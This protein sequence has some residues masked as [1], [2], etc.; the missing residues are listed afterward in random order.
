MDKLFVNG[1]V[2]LKG[3]V[4]IAGAKNAILPI[5]MASVMSKSSIL[6]H[7]I[8]HLRDVTM[9]LQLLSKLGVKCKL[10]YLKS[11]SVEID[12]TSLQST[13]PDVELVQSMRASIM[14]MGPLLARYG[15][16]KLYYPG[17]CVIGSRPIDLHI[18]GLQKMGAEITQD[19][20]YIFAR[21]TR[22]KGAEI[23]FP[24][25]SVTGTENIMSAAVLAEGETIINNAAL[26]PEVSNLANYLNQMGGKISGI[27]S[28]RLIIKGVKE[29][30]GAEYPIVSDRVEASTYLVAGI[31]T[32]GK[33]RAKHTNMNNF[34][35]VIDVL[36]KT[37]A[38]IS[39][40]NDWV[41]A[42]MLGKK[43]KAVDVV[44]QP[45]PGFPTDVQ[46]QIV[47]LNSVAEGSAYVEETIFESRFHHVSELQKMG[48]DLKQVKN[49]VYSN[50]VKLHGAETIA[51]DLRASASLVL[52]SLVA[53]GSSVIDKVQHIDRG[54]EL[55]EEKFS[56]LGADI[57]RL[58]DNHFIAKQK[59]VVGV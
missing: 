14:L 20:E 30:H 23:T 48:A 38:K 31:M 7:N 41:E 5:M 18:Q 21:A 24:V 51:S 45:F 52:A 2:A 50:G 36:K 55:I 33:V 49:K 16:V 54:Y 13:S 26:E 27:G 10:N 46:A 6:I 11:L 32:Q 4:E 39:S 1:G 56:C 47:A 8:P 35:A 40:G 37:G 58:H 3:D 12:S 44:T 42:D 17:G 29:L 59:S 53:E 25:V 9:T 57:H 34:Q 15:E 43:P 19:D 28:N 22:L